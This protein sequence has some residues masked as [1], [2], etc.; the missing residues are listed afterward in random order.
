M[1]S[2]NGVQS[3]D[4]LVELCRSYF[5]ARGTNAGPPLPVLDLLDSAAADQSTNQEQR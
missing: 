3:V 5:S 4:D 1:I 2:P